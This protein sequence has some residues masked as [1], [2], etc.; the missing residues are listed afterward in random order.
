M[1]NF[2]KVLL[3]EVSLFI[4]NCPYYSPGMLLFWA[5]FKA[6]SMASSFKLASN[7]KSGAFLINTSLLLIWNRKPG[8]D[9][10]RPKLFFKLPFPMIF[11]HVF[12]CPQLKIGIPQVC[13]M[14]RCIELTGIRIVSIYVWCFHVECCVLICHL[15]H[16]P[17][18]LIWVWDHIEVLLK[19][20]LCSWLHRLDFARIF[21]R[22]HDRWAAKKM[23]G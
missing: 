7:T 20:Q 16:H 17:P 15:L 14:R 10:C 5:M 18:Q 22:G 1:V 12:S 19:H 9:V 2:S 4:Q 21:H 3:Q 13:Q 8:C 6:T 23:N 11:E